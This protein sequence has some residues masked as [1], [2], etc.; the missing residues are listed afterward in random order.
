VQFLN[1]FT[2]ITSGVP[3]WKIAT[4]Q[5]VHFGAGAYGYQLSCC[6]ICTRNS[7]IACNACHILSFYWE[8]LLYSKLKFK[9]AVRFKIPFTIRSPYTHLCLSI[10][11]IS[12]VTFSLNKGQ[13]HKILAYDFYNPEAST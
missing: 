1:D 2:D 13:G 10:Q 11:T 6:A 8:N 3:F 9:N 4:R 12:G 7:Q 5:Q